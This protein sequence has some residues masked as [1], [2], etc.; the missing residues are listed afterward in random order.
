[1]FQRRHYEKLAIAIKSKLPH[2]IPTAHFLTHVF[3]ADNPNFKPDRF[4]EACGVPEDS[5]VNPMMAMMREMMEMMQ[6]G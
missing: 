4:L 2:S 5:S 3:K 1:M 6:N